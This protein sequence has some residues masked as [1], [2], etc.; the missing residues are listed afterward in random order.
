VIFAIVALFNFQNHTTMNAFDY[1]KNAFTKKYADFN[2]RARRSEYWYFVL[3]NTLVAIVAAIID[4]VIGFP[5]VYLVYALASIIPSIAVAV[6][7]M[8]DTNKSGWYLLLSLI[9]LVGLIVIYFLVMDSDEGENKY[10]PNP[11][12]LMAYDDGIIDHMVE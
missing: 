8:H 6:R 7:R 3:F 10:G 5:I 2:G 4:S 9:P 11:K 1:Y 12:G